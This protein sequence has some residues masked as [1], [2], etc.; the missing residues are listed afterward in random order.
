MIH[1][2]LDLR[3]PLYVVDTETTGTD[4]DT[5]RIVELGFQRW[6]AEGLI[7]ERRSLIN[8]GIPIPKGASDVHHIE[9]GMM[10]GCR[11][12]GGFINMTRLSSCT[13]ATFSPIY[14]FKQ[15]AKSLAIEFSDCDFA[16]KYV[17]FDLRIIAAEMRR[18]GV[19]WTYDRARIVDIDRLEALANPRTLEVLHE[20]YTGCKHDGAHGALSD[21]RASTTVIVKQLEVHEVLPRDLD[22][23]HAL[24]W[25]G[26]IDTE[27]KFRFVDGV[28]TVSFGKHENTAMCKVD[29]GYWQWILR[30]TFNPEIKDIARAALMGMYPE[31]Q[32]GK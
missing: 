11:V 2:L 29:S 9:D 6:E 23:L 14:A 28:P 1:Q 16:G 5:D 8:P 21:V 10:F 3:R 17:R 27:G 30:D 19:H 25:P 24:Q 20:K 31:L 4:D 32:A 18:S 12:C 7:R 13:C 15:V 22:A 26:W